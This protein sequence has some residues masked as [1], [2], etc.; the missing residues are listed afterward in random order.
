MPVTTSRSS[1]DTD[2]E[3]TMDMSGGTNLSTGAQAG[4]GVAC[5]LLG[6]AVVLAIGLLLIRRYKK[7]RATE[8]QAQSQVQRT[9]DPA[10]TTSHVANKSAPPEELGS[11]QPSEPVP[12]PPKPELSTDTARAELDGNYEGR[13]K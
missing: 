13:P 8:G 9:T 6:L 7:R 3:E 1:N 5:G 4:I 12:T 10:G 2:R 11:S